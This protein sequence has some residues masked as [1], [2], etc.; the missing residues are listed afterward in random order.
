MLQT[1]NLLT[2]N[3]NTM[4][5]KTLDMKAWAESARN[6]QRRLAIPIMTHP[7]IEL[8]G[9]TVRDAVTDGEV[10][11][12]AI[13]A[14]NDRYPAD[15]CSV[16]MDLTVEA[17]AFGAHIVFPENEVPSVTDTLVHDLSEIE[18]LKIPTLEAGR[19][20]QYLKANR[21]V[22]EALGDYEP[23]KAAR[24]VSEFVDDNL[25]NWYVRLNRKRFW[26]PGK[27]EDK[28][29]AYQ[30]L[31]TCLLTV[32]KLIA[33]I[34]PFYSDRLYRDL[35]DGVQGAPESVHLALFPEADEALIN[36]GLE[37]Q[38]A[39]AQKLTSLVLS[40]RKK[41]NIKVRQPLGKMLVP[42]M[43]PAQR[44]DLEA[45]KSLV[46]SEVN[47]KELEIADGDNEIFVKRVQ[48]D[49]KKLGPKF[50]KQMKAAAAI[51]TA[52][53]RASIAALERDGS[54]DI[55]TPD[56]STTTVEL[57]DV[58]IFSEDI[59]GWLVANEGQ[60][61]VALDIEID[62]ALAREGIAREIVNRVQNLRKTSGLEIT[63]HITL[64]IG[65]QA[66]EEIRAAVEDF[67]EYIAGQVIADAIVYEESDGR[68]EEFDLDGVAVNMRINKN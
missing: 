5:M 19:I 26:G 3:K 29:A 43:T 10:H 44:E 25:S 68:F 45:V 61:T 39:T 46:L 16:I 62:T 41:A 60:L 47:V 4:N 59:P 35:T 21:I 48:P 38:M 33:P 40:L 15:A 1:Q 67:R 12:R 11:A 64:A 57:G 37:R 55:T 8:C 13:L 51:I 9:Y 53:D 32:V 17:E 65:N 7:G 2:I 22:A 30:T 28:L 27:E 18:A 6:G 34:A 66:S 52:L 49:F 58:K 63:D 24:A 54:I 23:T 14:L 36:A 56:G 20:P 50:G 31:Y 42:A